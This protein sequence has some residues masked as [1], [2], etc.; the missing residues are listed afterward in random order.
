MN[1][2]DSVRTEVV[3]EIWKVVRWSKFTLLWKIMITT[4]LIFEV[5]NLRFAF[6]ENLVFISNHVFEKIIA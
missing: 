3:L 5:S 4:E 6:F 2:S 1:L